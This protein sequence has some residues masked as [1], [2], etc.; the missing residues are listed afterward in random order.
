V[1]GL[2]SSHKQA[3]YSV[4]RITETDQRQSPSLLGS[5]QYSASGR[6]VVPSSAAALWGALKTKKIDSNH[7]STR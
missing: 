3:D 4:T 6:V 5:Q 7:I 2:Q 1:I